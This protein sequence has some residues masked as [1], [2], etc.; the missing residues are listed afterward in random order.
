MQILEDVLEITTAT[1][2]F[3]VLTHD[4]AL[5]TFGHITFARGTSEDNQ[6]IDPSTKFPTG[7]P[8]VYACW[9]FLGMDPDLRVTRYWYNNGR[10]GFSAPSLGNSKKMARSATT[11]SGRKT[12]KVSLLA[13]GSL[14]CISAAN[15][16]RAANS[17]SVSKTNPVV[18]LVINL[19][20]NIDACGTHDCVPNSGDLGMYSNKTYLPLIY[21]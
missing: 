15:L 16:P 3:E 11:P 18:I 8:T 20:G 12:T 14:N 9:D 5:P 2:T 17:K 4:A 6:P 13:I 21:R 7:I 19:S 10:S 1:T